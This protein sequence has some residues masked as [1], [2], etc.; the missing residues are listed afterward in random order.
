MHLLLP[1]KS[2]ERASNAL[3]EKARRGK[4]KKYFNSASNLEHRSGAAGQQDQTNLLPGS[5]LLHPRLASSGPILFRFLPVAPEARGCSPPCPRRAPPSLP[6]LPPFLPTLL[7]SPFRF[8]FRPRSPSSFLIGGAHRSLVGQ[9]AN[10]ACGDGRG[11]GSGAL[12]SRLPPPSQP[13]AHSAA[14]AAARP[15][16]CLRRSCGRGG[17]R[18]GGGG[19]GEE[20]KAAA[21]AGERRKEAAA[22]RALQLRRRPGSWECRCGVVVGADPAGPGRGK[23]SPARPWRTTRNWTTNGSR[24]SRTKAATWR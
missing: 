16:S 24:I 15:R 10:W 21:E 14:V 3:K 1:V 12:R 19:R 7:S 9:S 11:R 22:R 20:E 8:L 4:K 6:V 18:A 2:T 17:V 23:E 5:L 13:A